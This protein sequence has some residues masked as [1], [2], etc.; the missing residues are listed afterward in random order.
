[1]FNDKKDRITHFLNANQILFNIC[2]LKNA[3]KV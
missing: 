1:M 2:Y 3:V